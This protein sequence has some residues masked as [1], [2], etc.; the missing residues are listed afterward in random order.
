MYLANINLSTLAKLAKVIFCLEGSDCMSSGHI[1]Y[2]LTND[3]WFVV[4]VV[5]DRGISKLEF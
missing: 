3:S 1:I 5:I 2:C 4:R